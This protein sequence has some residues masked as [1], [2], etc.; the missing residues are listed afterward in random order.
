PQQHAPQQQAPWPASAQPGGDPYADVPPPEAPIDDPGE[1]HLSAPRRAQGEG[2]PQARQHAPQQ[3]APQQHA[4][5]QHAPQQAPQQPPGARGAPR[6]APEE[7]VPSRDDEDAED[8]QLVGAV[9]VEQLLGGK[10]IS[11][12]EGR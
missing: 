11:T 10:V 4:P 3:H 6:P 2:A 1:E 9:V 7:D 8:S 5:R 12:D